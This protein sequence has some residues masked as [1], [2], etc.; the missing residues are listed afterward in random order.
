[1]KILSSGIAVIEGDTHISKWVEENGRLDIAEQMLIPF[2]KYIPVGGRVLD[3]GANIGDHTATYSKWVGE[4]GAV[5]AFEPNPAAYECL[6]HNF[7]SSKNVFPSNC[8]LSSGSGRSS[9]VLSENVGASFLSGNTGT[10]VLRKL[11]EYRIL[12]IDF[13]KID[14]EGFE[15]NVLRG[16]KVT[17][18]NTRPVMLIEVNAGALERAGTSSSELLSLISSYGYSTEIT[19]PKLNLSSLQF[20]VL[21]LPE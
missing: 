6:C 8:A 11:D 17:I 3:I 16:A 1:M 12:S 21:C 18:Q 4:E 14:V 2:R 7:S 10:V 15:T 9:F 19:D 13:I 20:D 5:Y